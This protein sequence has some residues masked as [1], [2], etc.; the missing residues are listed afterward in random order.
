MKF[1]LRHLEY[2]IAAGE[3]VHPN[4]DGYAVMKNLALTGIAK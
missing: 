2:F 4:R 3:T 1:T